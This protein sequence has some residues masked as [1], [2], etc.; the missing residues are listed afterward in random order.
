M[1]TAVGILVL[2]TMGIPQV[3]AISLAPNS[4][5]SLSS[6]DLMQQG[7]ELY[8]NEQ[9]S[10]AVEI[11]EQAYIKQS[12]RASQAMILSNLSLAYQQL[13]QW[14]KATKAISS[15]LNILQTSPNPQGLAQALLT[16]G[17]LQFA[18]GQSQQA[19]D[20]W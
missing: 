14:E 6:S 5:Q 12:D 18:R 2:M 13:G 1:K 10:K 7:R 3:G 19:L 8:Q 11:W 15:S 4:I 9:F 16:Q 20:T 17:S